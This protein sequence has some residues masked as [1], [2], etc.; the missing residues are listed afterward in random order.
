M[1]AMKSAY[2][3][4]LAASSAGCSPAS[5]V[6]VFGLRAIENIPL[7]L[8]DYYSFPDAKSFRATVC[9]DL[10]AEAKGLSMVWK[11]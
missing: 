9:R 6:A 1:T 7:A 5:A 3:P 10:K 2:A 8:F 4:G 11:S